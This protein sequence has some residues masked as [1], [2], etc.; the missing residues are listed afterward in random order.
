MI[1]DRLSAERIARPR[2][3]PRATAILMGRNRPTM[4]LLAEVFDGARLALER[5]VFIGDSRTRHAP[6]ARA[7]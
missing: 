3:R 6:G 2:G 5:V 7:E 1:G 4:R